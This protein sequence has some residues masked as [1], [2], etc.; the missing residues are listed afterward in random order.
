MIR[1]YGF[2]LAHVVQMAE[3][4]SKDPEMASLNRDSRY[5]RRLDPSARPLCDALDVIV[6]VLREM[7]TMGYQHQH[8]TDMGIPS[9][10]LGKY[11]FRGKAALCKFIK[12]HLASRMGFIS[13]AHG[14]AAHHDYALEAQFGQCPRVG[15]KVPYAMDGTVLA[16]HKPKD[17]DLALR[18][19]SGAKRMS[20]VNIII[21][22]GFTSRTASNSRPF[23]N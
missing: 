20:G 1:F 16:M 12:G 21:L 17:E 13:K 11:L 7:A 8:S 4:I 22:N 10:S 5:W 9:G 14:D 2:S 15:I 19:Y 18:Y 23:A 3:G 6:L